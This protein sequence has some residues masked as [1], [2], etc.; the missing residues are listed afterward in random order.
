MA[1]IKSYEGINRNPSVISNNLY[2][3]NDDIGSEDLLYSEL[4]EY[5]IGFTDQLAYKDKLRLSAAFMSL[6]LHNT[7]DVECGL[8]VPTIYPIRKMI[9]S[10]SF[11]KRDE[12]LNI[13]KTLYQTLTDEAFH[14]QQSFVYIDSLN[15]R[16]GIEYDDTKSVF[17]QELETF[18][19]KHS[20]PDLAT[21]LVAVVTETRIAKELGG[22]AKNKHL[23]PS[24]REITKSHT[25]DEIVHDS[26]FKNLMKV[27]WESACDNSRRR[28]ASDLGE[29][30]I[31]RNF[32]D[33]SAEFNLIANTLNKDPLEIKS[34]FTDSVANYMGDF[35]LS[36][37]SESSTLS[38]LK[39]LGI[40][41][42][43]E[44][45]AAR[46]NKLEYKVKSLKAS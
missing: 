46:M 6:F 36:L 41:D 42:Y 1:L 29:I 27:I 25:Y 40:T 11:Y 2:V 26:L 32:I 34:L 10:N 45:K 37:P 17:L 14:A 18:I 20:N 23:Y 3:A 5:C 30:C 28:I 24:V 16:F 13:H 39:T 43:K 31:L 33:F 15:K 9:N 44:F 19:K 35:Q 8:V 38:F 12:L 7:I 21:I 22:Y 4:P